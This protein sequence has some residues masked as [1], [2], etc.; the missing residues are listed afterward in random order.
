MAR[1][2]ELLGFFAGMNYA[3]RLGEVSTMMMLER[4]VEGGSWKTHECSTREQLF[5]TKIKFMSLATYKRRRED[6]Q[7]IGS[8]IQGMTVNIARARM[9][10][11]RLIDHVLTVEQKKLLEKDKV[12]LINGVPTSFNNENYDRIIQY[13]QDTEK[14]LANTEKA[15]QRNEKALS[16]V[17]KE[18]KKEV[19][20]LLKA[21][22]KT[23]ALFAKKETPE[24]VIE[25][26]QRIQEHAFALEEMLS[27]FALGSKT[28]EII[29]ADPVLQG[30]ITEIQQG[31]MAKLEAFW[32]AWV[33]A[34][35]DSE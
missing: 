10:D 5:K 35:G 13:L 23:K 20:S 21:L 14:N 26:W 18:H 8:E 33:N 29:A 3:A 22:E 9:E 11:V 31:M 19:E 15:Y 24:W 27:E 6:L 32:R 7:A 1:D 28:A 4:Y 25:A 16:G 34:F 17:E 30:K 2:E 12:V